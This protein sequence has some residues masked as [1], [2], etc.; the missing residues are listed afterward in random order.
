MTSRHGWGVLIAI[1]N[2]IPAVIREDLN[3][4]AEL[5]FINVVLNDNTKL[6]IGAFYQP[7]NSNAGPQEKLQS[8]VSNF[9][10]SELIIV[11]DFNLNDFGPHISQP[12]S[13]NKTFSLLISSKITFYI[14]W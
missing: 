1:K 14:R 10:S 5:L 11:G 8:C 9:K 6:T 13:V 3:C 2:S 4:K 7:P 12:R